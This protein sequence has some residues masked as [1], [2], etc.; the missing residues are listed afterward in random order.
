MTTAAGLEPALSHSTRYSLPA[1]TVFFLLKMVAVAGLTERK[2][3]NLSQYRMI[4][5]VDYSF[6]N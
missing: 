5:W 6:F 4:H 3:D 2:R 1:D